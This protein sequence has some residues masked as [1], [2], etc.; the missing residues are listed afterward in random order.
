M[1]R[2]GGVIPRAH[3]SRGALGS[4]LITAENNRS[5]MKPDLVRA[6]VDRGLNHKKPGKAS[7][8]MRA[9]QATHGTHFGAPLE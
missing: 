9:A 6:V 7:G 2:R 1:A 4:L 8:A 3:G 5:A